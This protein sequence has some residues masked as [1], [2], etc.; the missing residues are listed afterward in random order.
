MR[1]RRG[2][3]IRRTIGGAGIAVLA[4]VGSTAAMHITPTVV[5]NKRADVIRKTLPGATKFFVRSV[6]IGKTDLAQI[7]AAA[8]FTPE[9]PKFDFFYGKSDDGRI[10]GTVLFPQVNTQH[11]PLEVGLTV[12]PSGVVTSAIVTKATVETKPWMLAAVRAGLMKQ[13]VGLRVGTHAETTLESL[14]TDGLSRMPRYM[15]QVAAT[16]VK[17]GLTL[18]QVLYASQQIAEKNPA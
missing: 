13:F 4:V 15:A 11:G 6:K 17:R 7:R 1:I 12:D 8:S 5:L 9:N 10:L 16:A 14:R 18:Y 2:S 3:R